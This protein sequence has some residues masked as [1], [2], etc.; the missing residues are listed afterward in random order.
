[1]SNL[2]LALGSFSRRGVACCLPAMYTTCSC[3]KL[4]SLPSISLYL[5]PSG[6][7]PSL[8]L[9]PAPS[10]LLFLILS[11]I[12]PL[13]LSFFSF[14]PPSYRCLLPLKEH[15]P[16]PDFPTPNGHIHTLYFL[17]CIFTVFFYVQITNTIVLQLSKV[18]G[19]VI[20]CIV[21]QPRSNKLCHVAQVCS[22]LYHLGLGKCALCSHNDK[23]YK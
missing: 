8:P 15:L 12:S 20:Y 17:Y 3:A 22:R 6:P 4:T 23:N 9:S 16:S 13:S 18:F 19:T 2:L 7:V 21:F 11:F 10:L 14:L 1:M 5:S